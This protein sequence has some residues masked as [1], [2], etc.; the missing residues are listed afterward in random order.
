MGGSPREYEI[1]EL[2]RCRCG[3][4]ETGRKHGC[5]SSRLR[6]LLGSLFNDKPSPDDLPGLYCH[7]PKGE[8]QPAEKEGE[9]LCPECDLDECDG[10]YYCQRAEEHGS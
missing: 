2:Q 4:C 1:E 9:C 3:E 8:R 5:N 7:K 6:E 10:E